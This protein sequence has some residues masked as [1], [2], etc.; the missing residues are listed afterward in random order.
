MLSGIGPAATLQKWGIRAISVLAGVGQNMQDHI[1]FGP[2]YRVKVDT[3]TKL[4]NDIGYILAQFA[5]P[6]TKLLSGP[7]TNPIC[8]Y[9]GWEKV[10]SFLKSLFSSSVQQDLAKFPADWPE[11]EYLSAPGYVGDFSS[12]PATQP[13]DGYQY[14]S[15]LAALVA[16]LSRGTVTLASTNAEDL[17]IIDPGWL[18]STT[19]QAVAI[20]GWKRARAAFQTEAMKPVLA[21]SCSFSRLCTR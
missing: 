16:P 13:K 11:I 7:L 18:T 8:D 4:A 2:T 15:I 19:D 21:V 10:P 9:L 5:G 14:A 6:Y 1:F 20:A 12:L 3:F 17:P